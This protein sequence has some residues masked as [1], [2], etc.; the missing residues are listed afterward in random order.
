VAKSQVKRS[1]PADFNLGGA[2]AEADPLLHQAFFESGQYTT[3]ASK[4]DPR[5]F[6]VGRTGSGKSA[7][8][9][10]IEEDNPEH[11]VRINPEDLSLPYISDLG[12]VRFLAEMDVHLDPFFIA[13][14]ACASCRDHTTPV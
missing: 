6:I 5:C 1:L 11:V 4:D 12:V 14:E 8:L 10:R 3:L 2:Q 7:M 9:Q 13:L